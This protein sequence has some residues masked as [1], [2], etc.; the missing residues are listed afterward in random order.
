M[1]MS[2]NLVEENFD[3]VGERGKDF[4]NHALERNPWCKVQRLAFCRS[5]DGPS[6]VRGKG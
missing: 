3:D 5:K 4:W 2:D 1:S 6:I